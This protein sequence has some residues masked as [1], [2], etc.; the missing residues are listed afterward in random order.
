LYLTIG[1]LVY[2]PTLIGSN[3]SLPYRAENAIC[4]LL[5]LLVLLLI[6]LKISAIPH[7][8]PFSLNESL[9]HRYRY[10][11][12]SV[13][14]FT[15]TQSEKLVQSVVSGYFYHQ[16]M[17]ERETKLF[18]AAHEKTK[19]VEI[20]EYHLALKKKMAEVFPW[21]LPVT[22]REMI[23]QRPSLLYV[24]DYIDYDTILKYMSGA[25]SIYVK[26]IKNRNN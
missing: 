19:I 2:I 17:K 21:R 14:I 7:P 22:L 11:L 8:R 4:F 6:H 15:T 16:V 20:D 18:S 10:L 23:V 12:F 25:D 9:I 13:L 24:D 5:G 3:G 1:L 26:Q